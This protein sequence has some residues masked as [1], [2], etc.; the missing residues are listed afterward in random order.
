MTK[1]VENDPFVSPVR[2]L[3]N[4][5]KFVSGSEDKSAQPPYLNPAGGR[6]RRKL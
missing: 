5:L 4:T 2:S 1:P 6:M 3:V